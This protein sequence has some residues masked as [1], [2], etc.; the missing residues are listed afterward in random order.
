[1]CDASGLLQLLGGGAIPSNFP[2]SGTIPVH[3]TQTL[4]LGGSIQ[5][6]LKR[7]VG[8]LNNVA[9]LGASFD[10]GRTHFTN[11]T[12]LGNLVYLSPPGTTSVSDG[13]AIGGADYN[14][15]FDAANRY[16]GA[17]ITDT[18]SVTD[19]LNVTVAGRFNR[20]AL[21]LSDQFG[22]TLNG[23]HSYDRLNP[24]TGLT[25]QVAS[26]LNLYASYSE[27]NRIPT[28][29]ELSCA[30]PTQPCRF[31]LGF[32]SDP[33][34][35][36]VIARTFELGARGHVAGYD[37]ALDW[38]ADIYNT[39]N[40][41]DIIFVSSGPLIGSGYFRN[42]GATRRLGAEAELGG[43]WQNVDFHANYGFIRAT[44]QSYLTVA[45]GNNPG[46]DAN[47]N[48]FVQPGDRLPEVPMHISKLGAGYSAPRGVHVGLDAILVSGQYLRGD[49]AN[50][51]K[52]LSG[53]AVL[54]AHA[55][56]QATHRLSVLFEGEN[57]LDHRYHSFGLDGDP[58]G[59]GA[60][61][62]FSDPRFYTPGQPFGF[63]LGA[64]LRF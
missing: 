15:K 22:D 36:Q 39:S 19:A 29:A 16:F 46:A 4:G 45:S 33:D 23:S 7:T 58:T 31:P 56:W 60:F 63:W 38:S 42:A 30:D 50:L 62:Q 54:D 26:A 21:R 52:P 47:G 55:S 12:L 20:A 49:E 59:R 57:I 18:L 61:P 25:Y 28:A 53:Y 5:A 13:V 10:Q 1:V 34:L 43:T 11:S 64:Q 2:Y 37:F 40:Q 8:S 17:F 41:N 24:S 35:D 44:F 32:I 14:V 9:N 48:I 6:T 3:T 51:Q 27:A